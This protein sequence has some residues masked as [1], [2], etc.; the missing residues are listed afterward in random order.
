MKKTALSVLIGLVF[1]IALLAQPGG[2]QIEGKE[3]FKNEDVVFRQIDDHTW[4]GSGHLMSNEL[5]SWLSRARVKADWYARII[6]KQGLA[7]S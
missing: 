5:F 3:V 6:K 4:V 7:L 1:Q 2:V